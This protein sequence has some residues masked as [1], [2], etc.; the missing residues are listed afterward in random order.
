MKEL[1]IGFGAL[2]VVAVAGWLAY[3][4]SQKRSGAARAENEALRQGAEVDNRADK[5][6]AEPVAFG[7][8]LRARLLAWA[9]RSKLPES[10]S[11]GDASA[12]SS[13]DD[14]GGDGH[15]DDRR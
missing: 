13:P 5:I 1:L 15:G 4:R 12:L 2:V 8:R 7:G 9:Y 3:G 6:L 10:G 14:R 11:S